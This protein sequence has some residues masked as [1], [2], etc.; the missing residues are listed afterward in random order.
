MESTVEVK[1]KINENGEYIANELLKFITAKNEARTKGKKQ[2]KRAKRKEM[3]SIIEK[4]GPIEHLSLIDIK[5]QGH[6]VEDEYFLTDDQ[7]FAILRRGSSL[8]YDSQSK[9]YNIARSGLVKFFDYKKTYPPNEK[10]MHRRVCLPMQSSQKKLSVYLTEKANGENFQVSYNSQFE[11]FIVG[12]KNVTI[13]VRNEEDIEWY[14]KNG[15]PK[16]RYS[17]CVDFGRV[18]LNI[19][20]NKIKDK[21]DEF[22][23]E[24]GN[25][26]LVGESVGDLTRQHIKL[27]DERDIFF[28][29]IVDNTNTNNEICIPMKRAFDLFKKYNLSYVPIEPSE[30]FDN[31]DKLK[32]YV[33]IKY[34]EVLLRKIEQGGE[35][36]VAYFVEVD[37]KGNEKVLNLAK[38]KTFDYRFFRKLREI[39]KGFRDENRIKAIS[40][41]KAMKK[42][43]DD[44]IELLEGKESEVDFKWYMEFAEYYFNYVKNDKANYSD[45]FAEFIREMRNY[46]ANGVKAEDIPVVDLHKKVLSRISKEENE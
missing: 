25:H 8:T 41:E 20:K 19:V 14:I 11:C 21:I 9:K 33:D 31:Y 36:C 32:A 40:V 13:A 35:G 12:S 45:V 42:I 4:T 39:A 10:S 2:E 30:L 22:K 23:T 15:E 38:L 7:I 34:D 1:S 26:T 5:F 46:F 37:E 6:N 44:S 24:L 16:D 43:K 18:W 17:Y 3:F 29:A 27:Y 28:Y